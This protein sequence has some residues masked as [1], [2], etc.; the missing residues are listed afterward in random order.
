MGRNPKNCAKKGSTKWLQRAVNDHPDLLGSRVASFLLPNPS[1]IEWFS[2]IECDE[3]AEYSDQRFIDLLDLE[4]RSCPLA[5][6][7]P[8]RGGPNW[9]GLAKTDLS[10]VLLV[11]AKAHVEEIKE[12]G[13]GA[14]SQ[15]SI[16]KI[17]CSLKETQKFLGADLL[18]DWSKYPHY[19]YANRLAHLYFLSEKNCIDAYLL[20]IYFLND[21]DMG[22][23]D[24][25]G[26][27]EAAIRTH[28]EGMGLRKDHRMSDRVIN[29]FLDVREL[30]G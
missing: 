28:H 27:W 18:A 15:K 12:K 7:W 10:Q 3:Y 13:S 21:E 17:N 22:G 8:T 25:I 19:Q 1:N 24:S 6:F 29:L 2:P 5:R 16:D 30:G 26:Q 11:E 20:M 9:D 23:P 4:L 14:S